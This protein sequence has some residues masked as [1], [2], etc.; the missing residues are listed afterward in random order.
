MSKRHLIQAGGI[1]A[2]VGG[3][4]WLA[5]IAWFSQQTVRADGLKENYEPGDGVF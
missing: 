5:T 2:I 3:A 1:A 4:L